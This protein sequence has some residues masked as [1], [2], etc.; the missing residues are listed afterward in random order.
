MPVISGSTVI[1]GSRGTPVAQDVDDKLITVIQGSQGNAVAQ[2]VNDRLIAMMYGSA[3]TPVAQ[4]AANKLI[5][6]MQGS[7]GTDVA[8]DA[9]NKLITVIQGSQGAAVAQLV[10]GELIA[11]LV[12]ST[13]NPIAQDVNDKIIAVMQGDNGVAIA[14]DAANRLEAILY[15]DT[16][17]VAQDAANNLIAVMKGDY[18][19][20]LK[21]WKVD[22]DGRGEMFLNDTPDIWGN[23]NTVGLAEAA[24]RMGSPVSFDRRGTVFYYDN[25]EDAPLKW[26]KNYG[27][28]GGGV[29]H[30][31]TLSNE[32]PYRGTG[33]MRIIP[34]D[35]AGDYCRAYRLIG[36][37]STNR[38]G[39]EMN[40]LF[41]NTL[42]V[43][44][45]ILFRAYTGTRLIW[46]GIRLEQAGSGGISYLNNTG[47]QPH[48]DAAWT[49]FNDT[50]L[51][52]T[53]TSYPIKFVVDLGTEKYIRCMFGGIEINMSALTPYATNSTYCQRIQAEVY[54][55]TSAVANMFFD[56]MIL[57][58][59]EPT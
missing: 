59:E 48:L 54:V 5:S 34:P 26:L 15:G 10:T 55:V 12:G 24:V 16:G 14:Q 46:G 2:D 23:I 35:V 13:G 50:F 58:I 53:N 6:V 27:L 36:G 7:Q 1:R 42:N 17:V 33:S 29:G 18:L 44:T 28:G 39:M 45:S 8:Q 49:T 51:L 43:K 56:D 57:T 32:H 31:I 19:G 37:A 11:Q 3:G 30:S 25:F 4:D 40:I 47:N 52:D 22:V 20:A 38:I 41:E 9:A 21:T